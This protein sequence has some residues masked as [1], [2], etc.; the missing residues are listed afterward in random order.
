MYY[1]VYI[2]KS[3]RD[4]KFYTGMTNNLGKRIKEHNKEHSLTTSTRNRGP[5]KLIYF[6]K[7]ENRIKAREREK[8]FK[9]GSGREYIKRKLNNPE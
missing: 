3:E 5:F 2:L 9:S 7:L 8:Y 4:S 1:F 6:E